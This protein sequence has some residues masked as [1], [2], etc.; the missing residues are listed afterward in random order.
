MQEIVRVAKEE[1]LITICTIH[2]P[3][4]KVYNNF[5]Q[6]MILSRGRIAYAGDVVEATPY[7]E[8]IGYKMPDDT[9]PAEVRMTTNQIG[10]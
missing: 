1:K 7:F 4:S 3:S 2:Q 6:I 9:N 8:K 5:D 10:G